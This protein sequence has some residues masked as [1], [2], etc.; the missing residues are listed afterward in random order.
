MACMAHDNPL[1]IAEQLVARMKREVRGKVVNLKSVI[2]GRAAA[3]ELQRTVVTKERL[4]GYHPAHAAYVYAQNQMSVMSEQ[5]TALDEMAPFADIVSK[6]EAILRRTGRNLAK[7]RT[8]RYWRFAGNEPEDHPIAAVRVGLAEGGYDHR[9]RGVIAD[10][11][12]AG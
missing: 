2:A 3:E 12:S 10:A 11:A 7:L 5:L 9:H 1:R 8:L 4:A 6:A